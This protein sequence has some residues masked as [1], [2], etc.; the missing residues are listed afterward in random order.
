LIQELLGPEDVFSFLNCRIWCLLSFSFNQSP[1]DPSATDHKS[2]QA[3]LSLQKVALL[4]GF[5]NN[6]IN[7]SRFLQ[8]TLNE[9]KILLKKEIRI[10]PSI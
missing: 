1:S 6:Q 10:T 2:H 8:L 3:V 9:S 7:L 4:Q 5:K